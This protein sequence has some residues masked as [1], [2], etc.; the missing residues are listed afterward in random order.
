MRPLCDL[1][2]SATPGLG[3][4]R[5]SGALSTDKPL[6][7]DSFFAGFSRTDNPLPSDR[8]F[9]GKEAGVVDVSPTSLPSDDRGDRWNGDTLPETRGEFD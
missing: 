6:P 5:G 4:R 8:F 1:S 3:L 2:C 9:T 7:S